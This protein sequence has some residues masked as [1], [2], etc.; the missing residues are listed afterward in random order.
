MPAAAA[1]HHRLPAQFGVAQQLDRRVERVHVEMGDEARRRWEGGGQADRG[2]CTA[3]RNGT[4]ARA[5]LPERNCASASRK[6]RDENPRIGLGR[7]RGGWRFGGLLLFLAPAGAAA[8]RGRSCGNR[9]GRDARY[10][11]RRPVDPLPRS[12]NACRGTAARPV[13]ERFRDAG[14]DGRPV[15][16]RIPRPLLLSRRH[17]APFRRD[18][19]Q[20]AAQDRRRTPDAGEAR[21]RPVPGRGQPGRRSRS[22]PTMRCGID[23]ICW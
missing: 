14:H 20:P 7:R 2:R 19:R 6:R 4:P 15:R 12:G 5:D 13:R 17:G 8:G 9:A 10:D 23:P 22:A 18:H 16:P 11:G 1:D 3:S 21:T